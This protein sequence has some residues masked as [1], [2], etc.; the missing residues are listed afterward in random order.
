MSAGNF[1]RSRYESDNGGV[2]RIRIQPET[3]AAT[4]AGSVNAAPAGAIDQTVSARI[5]GGNRQIGVKA[6]SVSIAWTGAPPAGYAAN[7]LVRVAVLTPA[8]YNG[9]NLGDAVTYLGSSAEIVGK[10]PERVR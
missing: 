8:V 10:N 4:I 2:Y 7:E 5:G 1:V 3:A 6:R 9:A